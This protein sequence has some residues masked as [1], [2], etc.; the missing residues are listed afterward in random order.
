MKN[1][2][3]T[4]LFFSVLSFA[5][6]GGETPS[7]QIEVN[8][9]TVRLTGNKFDS[10]D[11]VRRM[12]HF[13]GTNGVSS[14]ETDP[15][16]GKMR[17]DFSRFQIFDEFDPVFESGRKVSTHYH[18]RDDYS[19][20]RW[21]EGSEFFEVHTTSPLR[22]Y[23]MVGEHDGSSWTYSLESGS[24]NAAQS[25]AL[26]EIIYHL[27]SMYPE[28]EIKIG[29]TWVRSPLFVNAYLRRDIKNVVGSVEFTLLKVENIEGERSAIITVE[30]DSS[31]DQMNE[32][33][34]ISLSKIV[35]KGEIVLSLETYLE[36]DISLK[37][38]MSGSIVRNGKVDLYTS[39][40]KVAASES[41]VGDEH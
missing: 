31:G 19:W 12:I 9:N 22:G 36:T 30:I 28:A 4:L 13:E 34:S 3:V 18:M 10:G 26:R 25:E 21:N 7:S 29:E 24:A 27:R 6:S 35:L 11:R 8:E 20:A 38:E 41:F 14:F 23:S 39:P 33:G 17:I 1:L 5:F 16:S 32:D 40:I 15:G 2:S 37:G